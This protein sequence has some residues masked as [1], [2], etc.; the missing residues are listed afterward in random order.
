MSYGHPQR[1]EG[2]EENAEQIGAIY[3]VPGKGDIV[4]GW[5]ENF[6][7]DIRQQGLTRAL[8]DWAIRLADRIAAEFKGRAQ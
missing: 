2:L 1:P 6:L 8:I 4:V 5:D 3:W 7:E